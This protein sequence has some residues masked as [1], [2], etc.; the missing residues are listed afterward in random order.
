MIQYL[1]KKFR[2]KDLLCRLFDTLSHAREA[3]ASHVNR[4]FRLVCSVLLAFSTP[5]NLVVAS[6]DVFHFK[7]C[8]EANDKKYEISPNLLA[9]V[10]SVESSFNPLAESSSGAL[11]LMQIKWPLTAKELGITNKSDLL[12]PCKNIDAGAKYL[13]YLSSRF[14]SKLLAIAAYFQGPTRIG[15][16]N[17]IPKKSVGYVERVLREEA[18]IASSNELK[19]DGKCELVTFQGLTQKTHHPEKRLEVAYRWVVEHHQFC[20]TPDLLKIR[21]RL[22]EL[23]GTADTKGDLRLL[24]DNTIR[25]K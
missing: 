10:A 13:A 2:G 11:G 6:G 23:M 12:D 16:K 19:R 18:L 8:F 17:D 5:I 14:E 3:R 20:S 21:N 15:K 1:T 25:K 24:I 9:A 7:S 4:F 22:P